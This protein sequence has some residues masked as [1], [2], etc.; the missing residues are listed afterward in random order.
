MGDR[1]RLRQIVLN[2]VSNAIKFTEAGEVGMEVRVDKAAGDDVE[3]HFTVSDT[4]IGVPPEKHNAIFGAFAQADAST[5]RRYGGTGLGLTISSRLV[6]MMGGRIWLNSEPGKGSRFHFTA[7]FQKFAGGPR[8]DERSSLAARALLIASGHPKTRQSLI[9]A[10]RRWGLSPAVA[11]NANEALDSL[12]RAAKSGKP[13]DALWCD[14][15]MPGL[16]GLAVVE[17]IVGDRL[18]AGLRVILVSAKPLPGD[19][20]RCRALGVTL[21]KKPVRQSELLAAAIAGLARTA[22]G[23]E[24]RLASTSPRPGQSR[25]RV[26]L[27]EDNVV[28]Q[29]VGSRLIEK[30]GHSVVVVGDGRQAVRA[31]EEQVFDVVFMDVQMPELDGLEAARAI[32]EK[33]RSSGQHQTIV[34]MTAH[35]M[36]GDR[37]RCLAAGMDGYLSKPIRVEELESILAGLGAAAAAD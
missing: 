22:A 10:A 24:T 28:N 18:L 15:H 32:R 4:G 8:E 26:L 25:L 16:D 11:A 37:E 30:L 29:R 20:D 36:K 3:L 9:E 21:L 13:Y 12:V 5:T 2:L 19:A 27:A 17:R 33:E 6:S 1:F 31:V 34:A 23:P 14:A 7:K 35:A